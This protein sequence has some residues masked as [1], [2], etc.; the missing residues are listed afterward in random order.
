LQKRYRNIITRG[1]KELLIVPPKPNGKRGKMAKSDAHNLW[2]RLK[3]NESAVLLFAKKSEVSFTNNRAE[4]DLRMSKVKQKVSGCFR[5]EIY[6]NA[7]CRTSSYLQTMANKG[8][9]PL[10]AIQKALVGDFS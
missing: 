7:Y 10:I 2:E 3:E 9:N 1:E 5:T 6:A 4:R 8:F